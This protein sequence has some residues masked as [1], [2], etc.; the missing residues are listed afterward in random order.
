MY[1]SLVLLFLFLF[2]LYSP[3]ASLTSLDVA[4]VP[5]TPRVTCTPR[6][7]P[8]FEAETSLIYMRCA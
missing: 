5:T 8:S 1:L 2:R 4:T 3:E 6:M 7:P